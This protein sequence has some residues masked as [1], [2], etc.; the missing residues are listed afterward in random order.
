MYDQAEALR[1]LTRQRQKGGLEPS[2]FNCQMIAV[3]S[4]KGGVGKTNVVVNLAIAVRRFG[5]KVAILDA[6]FGLANVDVLLRL[7]P[8]FHIGHV[9]EGIQPLS[10]IIVEGPEGI[11]I[12]PASSGIQELAEMDEA[13]RQRLL[14]EL[15]TVLG[16][17]DYLFIDTAPGISSNV[18]RF[19]MVARR[20]IVVTSPEPT[21]VV[22]TYALIKVL[23][24]KDQDRE[25]EILLLVNSAADEDEAREVHRQLSHVVRRFLGHSIHLFG[26]IPYDRRVSESVRRQEPIL[27]AYPKTVLSRQ[28]TRLGEILVEQPPAFGRWEQLWDDKA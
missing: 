25:K 20:I 9:I 7:S 22:D 27:I 8:P 16:N 12:I 21:A 3:T 10:S 2:N 15:K 19:L 14:T 17:Y 13:S 28:I 4:G 24:R 11:D 5:K 18:I 23:L 6:D 1:R 26:Y